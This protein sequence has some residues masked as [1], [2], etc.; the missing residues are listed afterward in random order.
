MDEENTCRTRRNVMYKATKTEME[1]LYK[2][3]KGKPNHQN[4]KDSKHTTKNLPRRPS[5][6]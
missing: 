3:E 4:N 2:K 1:Q 6:R 5:N